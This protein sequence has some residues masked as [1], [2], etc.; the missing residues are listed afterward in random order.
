MDNNIPNK[1]VREI[2]SG[3]LAERGNR[4][5]NNYYRLEEERLGIDEET[6]K[7]IGIDA[8]LNAILADKVLEDEFPVKEVIDLVLTPDEVKIART[9]CDRWLENERN[10]ET[11]L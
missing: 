3:I 6:A 7:K 8:K 5:I 10:N 4:V 1:V 2:I 9:K 11:N